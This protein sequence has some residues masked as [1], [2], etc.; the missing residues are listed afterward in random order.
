MPGVDLVFVGKNP[1]L[2]SPFHPMHR[3]PEFQ[4]L[5]PA[6]ALIAADVRADFFP[7]AQ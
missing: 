3:E 4:I 2:G 7:G 5:P 6:G 1:G